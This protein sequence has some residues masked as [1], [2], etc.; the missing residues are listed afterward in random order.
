MTHRTILIATLGGQPQI[1]TFALDWLYARGILMDEVA[2]VHLGKPRYLRALQRLSGEF[3][4]DRYRGRKCRFRPV[5]VYIDDRM[6]LLEDIRTNAD[7]SA[8]WHTIHALIRQVKQERA[9]IHLLLSGGRRM[10]ALLALSA[11]MLQLEPGDRLWHLYTPDALQREAKDGAI[12]HAPDGAE[13]RLLQ[14]PVPLL[15]SYF[16]AVQAL[17][18]MSPEDVLARQTRWL[19]QGDRTRCEAVWRALTPRQRDVLRAFAQGLNRQQVAERLSLSPKT[20]D[21]HKSQILGHCRA[22]WGIEDTQRLDYHFL[23]QKFGPCLPLLS[24]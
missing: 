10:M 23:A 19:D 13:V 8:V 2:V 17:A 21:S 1:V 11:A 24:S 6:T 9:H 12:L 14:I 5:P 18:T 20:V 16:P 22:I 7:A 3:P 4:G 15:G